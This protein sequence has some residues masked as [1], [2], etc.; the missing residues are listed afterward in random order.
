MKKLEDYK[1]MSIFPM[2]P[3]SD[4]Q[5]SPDGDKVIFTYTT[6]NIEEN[7]Y[8][9]HI[10]LVPLEEMRPRQ[11]TRG[12]YKDTTPRWSPDGKH[13]LFLSDRVSGKEKK[14]EAE[15]TEGKRKMQLWV[16]TADGG[17]ARCLTSVEGGV[18]RPEWSPDGKHILFYSNVFKG[19]KAEGSDVTIIRRIDYKWDGRGIFDGE[20]THIFSVSLEKGNVRQLTD[21]E[22]DVNAAAWSPDGKRIAFISNINKD[23]NALC[24]HYFKKIYIVS[25]EGGEPELLWDGAKWDVGNIMSFAWSPDGKHLAFSGRI[26]GDLNQDIYKSTDL[27]VIPSE[28]GEPMN[29]TATF[30]RTI[31]VWTMGAIWG[32]D[33]RTLYFTAPNHGAVNIYKVG[34]DTRDVEPVTEEKITVTSFSIDRACSTITFAATDNTTPHELWI[35]DERGVRRVTEMSKELLSEYRLSEPEEFWVT[36]SEG[37][38]VHGWIMKPYDFKEGEKYPMILE[39]HGGPHGMY[40]YS[41]NH[42]FQALQDQGYVVLYT[43]PRASTGYGE[44]LA[45]PV[46]GLWGE[47]DSRDI[48][49]VVDH[50]IRTYPFI[51]AEKLGVTG[52]SYGGYMTNWLIGHTNRFKAAVSRN[53]L[54]NMFSAWGTSDIGWMGHEISRAKTPWDNLQFYMEQSPIHFIKNMETPLLLMHCEEDHR[55]PMEQS[56]QLYTGLKRLNKE[57]EFVRFPRESHIMIGIGKPKHRVERIQ[58]LVRWFDRYLK[59]T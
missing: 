15:E 53:S 48:M 24:S 2:Q 13:I 31:R 4:P 54:T 16:I 57:V 18:Q 49:E 36:T 1:I 46:Y 39:V 58:H 32:A 14:S 44:A 6:I 3:V 17:E 25:V 59:G 35:K 37:I 52:L 38:K 22:F 51:D 8:D 45:A 9:S 42:E 7:K 41:F 12:T 20:R 33:S 26:I 30:D 27:W 28:G 43:N 50:V 34:L 47:L 10:W 29:L 55:C 5:I 23:S 21:G 11:F 19:E 56:E 40:G